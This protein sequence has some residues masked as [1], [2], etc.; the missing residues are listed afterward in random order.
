MS[1]KTVQ[2]GGLISELKSQTLE[3]YKKLLSDLYRKIADSRNDHSKTAAFSEKEIA[4]LHSFDYLQNVQCE[5]GFSDQ[6]KRFEC[7]QA[8]HTKMVSLLFELTKPGPDSLADQ[9]ESHL[10]ELHSCITKLWNT[11]QFLIH[12]RNSG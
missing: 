11:M 4:K 7:I 1:S 2:L 6:S 9:L 3:G 5:L 10:T 12:C 8:K